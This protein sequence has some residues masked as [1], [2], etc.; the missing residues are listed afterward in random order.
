MHHP[1]AMDRRQPRGQRIHQLH[2]VARWQP[3]HTRS[4]RDPVGQCAQIGVIHDKIGATIRQPPH[5][6]HAHDGI[7]LDP[8]EQP[9]LFD[10]ALL[11]AFVMFAPVIEDLD[12]DIGRQFLVPGQRDNGKASA[13]DFAA[14]DI[15]TDIVREFHRRWWIRADPPRRDT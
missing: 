10:E 8:P 13:G 9:R 3:R 7:G 6:M 11:Q 2:Q 14:N 1:G 12:G 5:I 15:P 4:R